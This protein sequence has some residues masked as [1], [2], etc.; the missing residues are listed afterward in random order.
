M[1]ATIHQA[2]W[3]GLDAWVLENDGLQVTLLPA[4][5]GK[6]V[7]IYD[8]QRGVEWLAPPAAPPQAKIEY[9][10]GWDGLRS[11]GWDEMMPTIVACPYPGPGEHIGAALPDHGELWT[12][13]WRLE[14]PADPADGV[15]LR[16]VGRALPYTFARGARLA[17]ADTL[18]LDYSVRN[19]GPDPLVYLW[20]AHPQFWCEPLSEVV[21][22]KE[23]EQVVNVLPLEWGAQW[24]P[25]DSL[26]PWPTKPSESGDL[27]LD[28][29]G[30]ITLRGGRKF[31]VP[32]DQHVTW[33][34]LWRPAVQAG[35]QVSWQP[36]QTP[37]LGIWVDEGA[38]YPRSG[39]V[40]LEPSNGY[41]DSLALAAA[42]GRAAVLAPDSSHT[43]QLA[44]RVGAERPPFGD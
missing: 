4:P 3:G 23:V 16:A 6:I 35:L 9:G 30:S 22:P 39:V 13:A 34:G 1:T 2:Q 27:H 33:A 29:V 38:F 42:K 31:Y 10:S 14:A 20:A 24:G 44:V 18:V 40:A 32:P 37:Y 8:K 17:G 41:Y 26:N 12:E 28:R 7:S 5:G 25:Q 11:Y 21:L 36:H 19:D 15:R 43:W